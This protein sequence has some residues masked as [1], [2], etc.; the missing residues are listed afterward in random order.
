VSGFLVLAL[1][2]AEPP[3]G[4]DDIFLFVKPE[5]KREVDLFVDEIVLHDAGS[6]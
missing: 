5:G 2:A 3:E 1:K 4:H 6:P